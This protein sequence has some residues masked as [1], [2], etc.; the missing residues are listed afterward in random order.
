MWLKS[1]NPRQRMGLSD[2]DLDKIIADYLDNLYQSASGFSS[3]DLCG[4]KCPPAFA[5]LDD[6]Q[7][8]YPSNLFIIWT[9]RHPYDTALSW[10][11]R[12]GQNALAGHETVQAGQDGKLLFAAADYADGKAKFYRFEGKSGMG[13]RGDVIVEADW[14]IGELMNTLESEGLLENT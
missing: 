6:I 5:H 13:P 10:I 8:I 12:F 1:I 2:S 14:C 11:E 9:Y 3:T 4:D 7:R